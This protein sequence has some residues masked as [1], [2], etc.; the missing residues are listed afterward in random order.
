MLGCATA[1][2]R[3]IDL[4]LGEEPVIHFMAGRET[5]RASF[6]V[7]DLGDHGVPL[8]C[9]NLHET[10]TDDHRTP[11]HWSACTSSDPS[12]LA[13]GSF[14]AWNPGTVRSSFHFTLRGVI[15]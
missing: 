13:S 7:R 2:E 5:A 15:H 3:R 1:G 12:L 8:L 9:R 14:P 6:I 11:L 4:T 10:V